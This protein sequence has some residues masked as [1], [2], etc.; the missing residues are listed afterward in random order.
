MNC[1]V[2]NLEDALVGN[3]V[4]QVFVE[5]T[6]EVCVHALVTRDKL[7]AKSEPGH[8][9]ALFYPEDC[10]EAS[11][12][13]DTLDGRKGNQALGVAVSAVDPFNGPLSFFFYGRNVRDCFEEEVLLIS[14]LAE[15]VDE[16][17]VGLA[18][19][20]LHHH[21]EAVEASGF[22][23]LDFGAKTLGEIFKN[24]TVRGCEKSEDVLDEM[25]FI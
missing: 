17:R 12:E 22:G 3:F 21:L 11:G 8:K 4:F 14:V 13:E 20:V 15:G 10:T 2:D 6:G 24:N 16:D 9:A 18:V 7:V 25:L 19:D 23:N 1:T 5:K